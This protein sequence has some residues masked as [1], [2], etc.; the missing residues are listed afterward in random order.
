MFNN[1]LN[2]LQEF[3]LI[4]SLAS[5]CFSVF[6]FIRDSKSPL[7]LIFLL[8]GAFA[9]R[10]FI[11]SLDP[12]LQMWDEQFHA[13]V[14]KNMID[15]PF[16]PM[17][18][19]EPILS[20]DYKNWVANHVWLHKQPLFL[21][22]MAI[23]L[24]V[25]GISEFALRF[26]SIIMS[27][28]MVYF[29][30][31]MGK[32]TINQTVGFCAALLYAL[33]N[34][35]VEMIAGMAALDH[36]DVAFLFY[37]TASIWAWTEYNHS[38]K[39]YWIFLIG[40]F[41][42][43]AI[44]VKWLVGLLVY[45]GWGISI[46]FD[47]EK[48]RIWSSYKNILIASFITLSVAL[49]WQIYITKAFPLESKHEYAYS[50]RHLTEVVERHDGEAW[51][52]FDNLE[53]QYGKITP[54]II[55][56]ALYLFYR[57]LRNR[58][59]KIGYLSYIVIVYLFFTISATK[60]PGFTII[61]CSLIF[62]ALGTFLQEAFHL[63]KARVRN[64]YY[65]SIIS[66]LFLILIGWHSLNLYLI[67]KL[68]SFKYTENSY[69]K[70]RINSTLL[71]NRIDKLIFTDDYVIFNCKELNAIPIMFY[72]GLTAYEHVVSFEDYTVLKEKNI[73][74]AVFDDGNLPEYLINDKE[75]LKLNL[76][77]DDI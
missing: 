72:T 52:H 38:G 77:T 1:E 3:T 22:Q 67:E 6:L 37:V 4:L 14:A 2:S 70:N 21:W 71:A 59:F 62:I 57:R 34:Y 44:L 66:S 31:R 65:S 48:R 28:I 24:K 74:L 75:V 51:F 60:V 35:Q 42:G 20:Y 10:V 61:V 5:V 7:S 54:Y 33:S 9:L 46:L 68:H 29:I 23:S 45:S 50:S 53:I 8:S 63:I 55:L 76:G 43:C 64:N 58:T 36:N 32:I 30:Y 19:V 11:A 26:P 15:H 39:K 49:P 12:F 25:F 18:Y 73:K 41:S 40:L 13:L 69:R 47:S 56:I 16:K 27:T 17:L